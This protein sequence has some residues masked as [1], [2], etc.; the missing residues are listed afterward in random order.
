MAITSFVCVSVPTYTYGKSTKRREKTNNLGDGCVVMGPAPPAQPRRSW[1]RKQLRRQVVGRW[2][3]GTR[4]NTNVG[5]GLC[6][7][8]SRRSRRCSAPKHHVQE[9]VPRPVRLVFDDVLA[10]CGTTTT[11]TTRTRRLPPPTTREA[12]SVRQ[13]KNARCMDVGND[14]PVFPTRCCRSCA[15]PSAFVADLRARPRRGTAETRPALGRPSRSRRRWCQS[16]AQRTPRRC[17]HPRDGQSRGKTSES[18]PNGEATQLQK[19]NNKKPDMVITRSSTE[20][21]HPTR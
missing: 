13:K 10:E 12:Y 15:G 11:T 14:A 2:V 21:H 5:N 9:R 20:E 17:R 19:N 3:N 18:A 16:G 8:R 6:G 1:R 4:S 7:S